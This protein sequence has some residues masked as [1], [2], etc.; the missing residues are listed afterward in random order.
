MIRKIVLFANSLAGSMNYIQHYKSLQRK[1]STQ[2]KMPAPEDLAPRAPPNQKFIKQFIFYGA[3]GV[4]D[5][6]LN[7]YRLKVTGLVENPLSFSYEELLRLPQVKT[8]KDF[9]CLV[10]SS[11]VY[12]NPEPK[13][14]EEIRVG[15]KIVGADGMPHEVRQLVKLH[16]V[17]YVLGIKAAHLPL[18]KVTPDHPILVVRN[19]GQKS[20]PSGRLEPLWVTAEDL[21]VDD[22]VFFPRYR[23]VSG[24][25]EVS[26][27][28]FGFRLDAAL[29]S[30]L[31]WYV[32][33]GSR[34]GADGRGVTFSLDT[35][36]SQGSLR[37]KG[38]L[39]ALFD[40]DVSIEE[41][42]GG[43][44]VTA[45]SRGTMHL[46][47]IFES[48]CGSD[49]TSKVIPSFIMDADV[50]VLREF[51]ASLMDG[52]KSGWHS[53]LTRGRRDAPGR[54][55]FT[56]VSEPLAYQLVLALSKLG[57]PGSIVRN[58]GPAGI[59]YS[60]G[61]PDSHVSKLIQSPIAA[62]RTSEPH[63]L[64]TDEGFYYPVIRTWKESYS[65]PVYDFVADGYTMLCPFAT[66]DCVTGWSV[67]DTVWEGPSLPALLSEARVKPEAQFIMFRCLDGYDTP[68]PLEDG[69]AEGSVIA[70]KLNGQPLSLE[71]GFPARPFM[72]SLY[73]WKSAKW[74]T[75]IELLSGYV[76]GYWEL[77]GYH[78]RGN[79]WDEERFKSW[80]KHERRTVIARR[81][82]P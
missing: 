2:S 15:D 27:Q 78:E 72:P 47:E 29:A 62:P 80:G 23:H 38:L 17:G 28:G 40:A 49:A 48:W 45:V 60:V 43:L 79:V 14:V 58:G 19:G 61:V 68:I 11:R 46:Q 4:P 57:M 13:P 26:W 67:A 77:R 74:L 50:G 32:A 42:A 25:K 81:T 30:V 69:R 18:V 44:K 31:G 41:D 22:Y 70:L 35:N 39:E 59:G 53:S 7:G 3:L 65:G 71:M 51:L 9:H 52:C 56:V 63:I 66:K 73:G 37:L 12:A 10:P 36:Q 16:H 64:E 75:E 6:D 76:D 82:S 20:K 8:A 33:V 55:N 21:R 24:N 34:Y 5:V 54:M 1:V